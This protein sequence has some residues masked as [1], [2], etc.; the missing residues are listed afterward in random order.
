MK[1]TTK[2][3]MDHNS[4]NTDFVVAFPTS[5]SF[6]LPIDSSAPKS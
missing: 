1:D 4:S 6:H 3:T 2:F 5:D